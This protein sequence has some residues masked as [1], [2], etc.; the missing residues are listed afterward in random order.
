MYIEIMTLSINKCNIYV[1]TVGNTVKFNF[2]LYSGL[3]VH[4]YMH[5]CR[6]LV[7]LTQSTLNPGNAVSKTTTYTRTNTVFCHATN[8]HVFLNEI[9]SGIAMP[10][11]LK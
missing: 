9:S 5:T 3:I 8:S 11:R 1:H 2:R 6:M 4:A 7:C 10:S